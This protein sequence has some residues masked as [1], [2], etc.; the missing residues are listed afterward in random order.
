MLGIQCD[1]NQLL[2]YSPSIKIIA[3]HNLRTFVLSAHLGRRNGFRGINFR[4]TYL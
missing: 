3:K 4:G 2:A 1:V